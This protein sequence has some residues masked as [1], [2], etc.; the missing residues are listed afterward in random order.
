MTDIS[1]NDLIQ[2]CNSIGIQVTAISTKRAVDET[3]SVS[4]EGHYIP[5]EQPK[6]YSPAVKQAAEY[7]KLILEEGYDETA[8][9]T[10]L[11]FVYETLKNR[12]K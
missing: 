12:K 11:Q 10:G 6:Q 7:I 1:I 2:K 8:L 3:D 4:I 9:L 5:V